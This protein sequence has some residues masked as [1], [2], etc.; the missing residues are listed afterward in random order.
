MEEVARD[1]RQVL[2]LREINTSRNFLLR[3][4]AVSS[5]WVLWRAK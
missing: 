1:L 2:R 5:N 4:F 3:E